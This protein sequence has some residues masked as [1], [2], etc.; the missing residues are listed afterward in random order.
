VDNEFF[1]RMWQFR[2]IL[3]NR[4]L[5]K[6]SCT[7]SFRRPRSAASLV[8]AYVQIHRTREIP[9]VVLTSSNEETDVMRTP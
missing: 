3:F 2:N 1:L 4:K 8:S 7:C 6:R 9:V 5:K